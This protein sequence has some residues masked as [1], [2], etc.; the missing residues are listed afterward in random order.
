MNK[1]GNRGQIALEYAILIA[2]AIAAILAMKIYMQ[3]SVQG[4]LRESADELG[5]QFSP[6]QASFSRTTTTTDSQ[7]VEYFG[8]TF[9]SP[10]A[11]GTTYSYVETPANVLTNTTW[12]VLTDLTESVF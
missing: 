8:R 3:R 5:M 4:R 2:V 1:R 12:T 7:T 10:S 9:S 6:S 11:P